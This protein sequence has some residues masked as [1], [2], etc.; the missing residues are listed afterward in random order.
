MTEWGEDDGLDRLAHEKKPPP[1]RRRSSAGSSSRR[2]LRSSTNSRPTDAEHAGRGKV[3]GE[4]DRDDV[5]ARKPVRQDAEADIQDS[6]RREQFH[7]TTPLS[8]QGMTAHVI[9]E[10]LFV[11]QSCASRDVMWGFALMRVDFGGLAGAVSET[12]ASLKRCA[13]RRRTAPL[14]G[15]GRI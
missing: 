8:L 4:R 13:F 6:E 11:R 12:A 7:A 14:N 2:R 1:T 5:P 10:P 15:G 3:G 9:E